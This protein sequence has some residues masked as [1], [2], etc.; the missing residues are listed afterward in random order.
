MSAK[1]EVLG[2]LSVRYTGESPPEGKD[3]RKV[4]NGVRNSAKA[5]CRELNDYCDFF[6]CYSC[7]LSFKN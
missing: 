6:H 1:T 4:K 2:A 5:A 3:G 7:K